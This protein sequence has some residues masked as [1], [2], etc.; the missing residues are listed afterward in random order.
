MTCSLTIRHSPFVWVVLG[1]LGLGLTGCA[2]RVVILH[3]PLPAEAHN[4]LALRYMEEGAWKAAERALRRATRKAP[5]WAV[6]YM[7]LGFLYARQGRWADA[8]QAYARAVRLDGTC[9]DCLNNLAWSAL[10][11]GKRRSLAAAWVRRAIALGGPE[12]FR[13]HHTAAW[14]EYMRGDCAAAL[15]EMAA[16][17]AKAPLTESFLYGMDADRL[18]RACIP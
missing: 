17:L 8:F 14:V 3:D 12:R 9:A 10:R 1:V 18:R 11:S 7:N 6:P 4:D 2:H 5:R 16:A 13:Y 15:Q